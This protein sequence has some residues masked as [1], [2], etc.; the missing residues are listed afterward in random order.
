MSSRSLVRMMPSAAVIS[1][2]SDRATLRAPAERAARGPIALA[3]ATTSGGYY[4]ELRACPLPARIADE[5]T[6]DR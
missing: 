4:D 3:A 2:A 6:Q 5:G 1:M